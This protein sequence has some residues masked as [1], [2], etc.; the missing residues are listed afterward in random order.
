MTFEDL[1]HPLRSVIWDVWLKSL[2]FA[3]GHNQDPNIL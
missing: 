2:K 1:R 3:N